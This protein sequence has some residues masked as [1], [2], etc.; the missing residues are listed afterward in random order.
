MV[1]KTFTAEG[2]RRLEKYLL[3]KDFVNVKEASEVLG[4]TNPT[5][6]NILTYMEAIGKV[7]RMKM[8]GR[9]TYFLAEPDIRRVM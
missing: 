7:K 9:Y 4:V 8:G 2:S 1:K 5:A 3:E 6:Y